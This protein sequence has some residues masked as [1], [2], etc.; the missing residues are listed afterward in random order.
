MFKPALKPSVNP[1]HA[2]G[3]NATIHT[4]SFSRTEPR[5]AMSFARKPL[6]SGLIGLLLA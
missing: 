6:I 3:T 1:A 5:P 2:Y 4:A